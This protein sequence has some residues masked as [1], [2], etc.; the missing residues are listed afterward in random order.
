LCYRYTIPQYLII[1]KYLRDILRVLATV[2]VDIVQVC[3]VL[4]A[5]SG[6]WQARGDGLPEQV[7]TAE[8]AAVC[9]A[10]KV[11]GA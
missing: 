5:P 8:P 3:A 7:A 6:P 10:A 1:F 2:Q 4:L 9:A 11:V